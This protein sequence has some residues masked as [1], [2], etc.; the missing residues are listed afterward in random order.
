MN[1]AFAHL[2]QRAI[3]MCK[4]YWL[5]DVKLVANVK[6]VDWPPQNDL[7]ADPNIHLPVT[8]GGQNSL[9]ES[10]H[11][12]VPLVGIPLFSDQPGNLL[13]VEAKNM[14]VSILIEQLKAETLALKIKQVMGDKRYKSAAMAA[15][16]IRGSHPLTPSQRL[17][18]WID[19]IL[20]TGGAAR[21]K[22][23]AF[24][25]LWHEQYFLDVFLF[26]LVVTL[27]TI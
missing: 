17:V 16:I 19:H 25:Q 24:Q 13:R 26:L 8:N 9:M 3:W 10:I 12:D 18:G 7:V 27:A 5:K 6:I 20:Q 22:S 4:P 21:L 1:A 11:H 15:S 2:P 23:H 14:G